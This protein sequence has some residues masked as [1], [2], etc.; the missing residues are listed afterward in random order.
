VRPHNYR[1]PTGLQLGRGGLWDHR[2]ILL[3]DSLLYPWE[4]GESDRGTPAGDPRQ[5]SLEDLHGGRHDLL[6]DAVS[7]EHPDTM[8][9]GR[10]ASRGRSSVRREAPDLSSILRQRIPRR[11]PWDATVGSSTSRPD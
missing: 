7:G 6:A 10:R 8:L 2:P 5:D 9:S 3:L 11:A 1:A 4:R